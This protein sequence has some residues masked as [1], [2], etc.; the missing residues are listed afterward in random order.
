MTRAASSFIVGRNPAGISA[1]VL[2]RGGKLETVTVAEMLNAAARQVLAMNL[3]PA[4][5]A[6]VV[7]AQTKPKKTKRK[8]RRK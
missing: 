7:A 2:R 1:V 6:R 5:L 4:S 8:G 3:V